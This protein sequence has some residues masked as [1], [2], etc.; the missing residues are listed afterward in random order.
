MTSPSPTKPYTLYVSKDI[1]T[2]GCKTIYDIYQ[3][4]LKLFRNMMNINQIFKNHSPA[5]ITG[6]PCIA[7]NQQK[8]LYYGTDAIRFLNK[9]LNRKNQKHQ[10]PLDSNKFS[11]KPKFHKKTSMAMSKVPNMTSSVE[12]FNGPITENLIQKVMQERMSVLSK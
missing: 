1:Q 11:A 9:F 4:N 3:N 10:P 6:V 8:K 5:Y 12:N 2:Q 7:D